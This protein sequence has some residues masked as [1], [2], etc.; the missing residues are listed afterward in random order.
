MCSPCSIRVIILQP[1]LI[2]RNWNE[3]M[4]QS[5]W[6]L[7][8]PAIGIK[9]QL[10]VRVLYCVKSADD[11]IKYLKYVDSSRSPKSDARD[12]S[13][14]VWDCQPAIYRL[15]D[16]VRALEDQ[17][18][19]DC[20]GVAFWGKVVAIIIHMLCVE[21]YYRTY[22]RNWLLSV[23]VLISLLWIACWQKHY[24]LYILIRIFERRENA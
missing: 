7:G 4:S 21:M 20:K 11:K 10:N 16:G 13:G 17:R 5:I 19:N 18:K 14:T 22:V 1:P 23:Q 6:N 15:R 8:V 2:P 9:K 24:D 3:A 12:K